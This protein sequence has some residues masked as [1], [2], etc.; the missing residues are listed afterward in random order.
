MAFVCVLLSN[1]NIDIVLR[2]FQSVPRSTVTSVTSVTSSSPWNKLDKPVDQHKAFVRF[3]LASHQSVS[4]GLTLPNTIQIS[5][6]FKK[7]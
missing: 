2:V 6:K 1:W 5:L 3:T 7:H 4:A